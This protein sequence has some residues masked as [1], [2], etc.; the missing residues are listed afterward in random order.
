MVTRDKVGIFKLLKR[1]NCHVTTTS[2][3]CHSQVHGLR[4][5]NWKEAMIN[6][7]N[8]LITSGTW[9][10]IPRPANINVV[11]SMWLFKHKFNAHGSLSSGSLLPSIVA[12]TD[13]GSFNYF[14]GIS[15][16]RS[17]SG[18]FLSQSKLQRKFLSELICKIKT[19]AGPPLMSPSLVQMVTQ[20][21]CFYIHDRHDPYFTALNC[22]LR[23]V[24]GT[25]NYGPQLHVSSTTQL[26]RILMLIGLAALLTVGPH[27]GQVRVL[28]VPSRFQYA[29]IFTKGL[30][31]AL[32]IDFY[33]SLNV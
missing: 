20:S 1:M 7:Y 3:L 2:P 5:P 19:H 24:C 13:L 23:Y 8:A 18:L 30:P 11:R 33:S 26:S 17:A 22:I 32:F 14:L 6:E 29:N 27:L 21:V 4:D 15:T 31:T 12:M 9:V 16:Q 28:Y 25:L 10:L